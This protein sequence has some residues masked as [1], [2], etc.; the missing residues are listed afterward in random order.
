MQAYL[1]AH[2]PSTP[3]PVVCAA[4]VRL[5]GI[6]EPMFLYFDAVKN[7]AQNGILEQLKLHWTHT[8]GRGEPLPNHQVLAQQEFLGSQQDI[9]TLAQWLKTTLP[10]ARAF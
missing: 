5:E 6:E 2:K 3:K 9:A 4:L 1:P 8:L 7:H 10:R